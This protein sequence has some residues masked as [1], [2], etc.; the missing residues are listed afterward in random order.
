[1][2]HALAPGDYATAEDCRQQCR[3]LGVAR[4]REMLD[5]P[6]PS[7]WRQ[8]AEQWLEEQTLH[9]A[10][11]TFWAVVAGIATSLLGIVLVVTFFW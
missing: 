7:S 1:M 4:V 2:S 3:R 9:R 11:L 6:A 5:D 10:R 8:E